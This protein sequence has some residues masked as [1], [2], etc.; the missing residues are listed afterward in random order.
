MS[1]MKTDLKALEDRVGKVL[2]KLGA[3]TRER[4]GLRDEASEL[5][6]KLNVLEAEDSAGATPHPLR[7]DWRERLTAVETGLREAARELRGE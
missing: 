4:D 3:L 1:G 7:D 5:R 2:E 6:G